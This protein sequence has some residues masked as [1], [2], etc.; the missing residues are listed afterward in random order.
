[1]A[2]GVLMG[3]PVL[4]PSR[5]LRYS[6]IAVAS[7]APEAAVEAAHERN[8][9]RRATPRVVR[10]DHRNPRV[11]H[12]RRGAA[13]RRASRSGAQT[14]R[15][16]DGPRGR[17]HAQDLGERHHGVLR[18]RRAGWCCCVAGLHGYVVLFPAIPH[19]GHHPVPDYRGGEA[20]RRRL[21]REPLAQRAGSMATRADRLHRRGHGIHATG[22]FSQ[23]VSAHVGD[24][25]AAASIERKD[26]ELAVTIAAQERAMADVDRRISLLDAAVEKA[27][28][29]GK[30]RGA[31]QLAEENRKARAALKEGG[32]RRASGPSDSTSGDHGS[33]TPDRSGSR[34]DPVLRRIARPR[35]DG[36]R[37]A[38][39]VL[40]GADYDLPGPVRGSVDLCNR[41]TEACLTG[42]PV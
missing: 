15:A 39:P 23:L 14:A 26:I 40:R 4:F 18:R 25:S 10:H 6:A 35:H 12:A 20:H 17:S 21:T 30:T 32:S 42:P 27:T 34:A 19:G 11:P 3:R 33:G 5:G 41:V 22:V 38:D 9:R 36:S 2:P 16:R 37:A 24:R 28:A 1:M 31:L 7:A 8:S 13:A 29:M